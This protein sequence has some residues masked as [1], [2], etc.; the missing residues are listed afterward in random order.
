MVKF[1]DA[2][3][4]ELQLTADQRAALPDIAYRQLSLVRG[5]A[6]AL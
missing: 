3:L 6:E 1:L 4:G 5:D 2:V